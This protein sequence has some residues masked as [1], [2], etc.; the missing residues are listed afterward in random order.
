MGTTHYSKNSTGKVTGPACSSQ[1]TNVSLAHRQMLSNSTGASEPLSLDK[2]HTSSDVKNP[3]IAKVI[4]F[5]HQPTVNGSKPT[6]S[7]GTSL[8]TWKSSTDT[9]FHVKPEGD[10]LL[11]C[12]SMLSNVT[13]VDGSQVSIP[14]QQCL[15]SED[16]LMTVFAPTKDGQLRPICKTICSC[17][18]RQRALKY[19]DKGKTKDDSIVIDSDE[20]EVDKNITAADTLNNQGIL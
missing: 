15:A 2:Q 18:L 9:N 13:K 10:A 4:P 5:S 14:G 6:V 8:V 20:E 17:Q 1:Q 11:Q 3:S 12:N 19:A 7:A 16:G